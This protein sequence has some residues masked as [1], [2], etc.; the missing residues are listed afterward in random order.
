MRLKLTR[1]SHDFRFCSSRQSLH[2]FVPGWYKRFWKRPFC[3]LPTN[4]SNNTWATCVLPSIVSW[5]ALWNPAIKTSFTWTCFHLG[6]FSLTSFI[7]SCGR[8]R[9]WHSFSGKSLL[10]ELACQLFNKET[11]A[12]ISQYWGAACLKKT[13]RTQ[14]RSQALSSHGPREMKEP[15]NEVVTYYGEE[16]AAFRISRAFTEQN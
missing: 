2:T 7:C 8:E 13:W 9:S 5:R 15:G 6:E 11:S 14:P 16:C 1:A 4:S 12:P 3:A 10:V